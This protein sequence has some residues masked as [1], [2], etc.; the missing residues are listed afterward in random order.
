[1]AASFPPG[2]WATTLPQRERTYLDLGYHIAMISDAFVDATRGVELEYRRYEL[3][4]PPAAGSAPAVAAILDAARGR[5]ADLSAQAPVDPSA[6]LHTYFGDRS[7]HVVLERT[8][9]HVA[10]HCRQLEYLAVDRL[11]G[12]PADRLAPG[13]LLGL[14]LPEAIWDREIAPD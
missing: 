5:L 10:Q 3:R 12:A 13:D 14:P 11:G 1:M 6:T 7:T 2:S 8:A 9:W 4:A